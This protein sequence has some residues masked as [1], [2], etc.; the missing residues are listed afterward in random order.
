MIQ[1]Q[2]ECR[3]ALWPLPISLAR[4][5]PVTGVAEA[6]VTS[7]DQKSVQK[8][9]NSVCLLW[10]RGDSA[11]VNPLPSQV[12]V[13]ADGKSN[14]RLRGNWATW[15]GRVGQAE[16]I[17][18]VGRLENPSVASAGVRLKGVAGNLP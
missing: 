1:R 4:R 11:L 15:V 17:W 16:N 14:S 3:S 6:S 10:Q 18:F 12:S 9:P 8:D 7:I 5:N 13:P 2:K